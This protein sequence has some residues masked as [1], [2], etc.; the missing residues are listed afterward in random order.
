MIGLNVGIVSRDTL[1]AE[2]GLAFLNGLI[3]GRHPVPPFS[4]ATGIF[5]RSAVMGE[6]VFEGEPSAAFLNPIGSV[7]GGW[8]AAILDS[9][10]ACAVHTTLEP[11]QGYTTAEM[12]LNYIRP[13]LPQTGPV[14]CVGKL[15]H[16]G[17]SLATSEGSLVDAR[18][19]LL[20]HGTETCMIL[21]ARQ[22]GGPAPTDGSR[23]LDKA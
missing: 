1:V 2:A 17:A 21:G 13:V 3:E 15:I 22:A 8:T 5:L 23:L 10:M 11:G 4:Q 18:G 20:A 9:A 7:H 16:R 14:R 6:V 12:K 19:R